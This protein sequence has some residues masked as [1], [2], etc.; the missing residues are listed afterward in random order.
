MATQKI[1]LVRHGQTDYNLQG[2]VQG[3]GIDASLNAT[4]NAQAEAFFRAYGD[5]DFSVVH[6]SQLNR[7]KESVAGFIKKGIPH[8][9]HAA[10]NE[11]SW[12]NREG[13]RI[14]PEEDEYYHW[15]LNQWQIGK[16]S[17]AIEGGESPDDVAARQKPFVDMLRSMP[18][19]RPVLICM[20]G[21]AMR[22]LLCQILNYPLRCM[23]MFQHRNLCLYLLH[24]TQAQFVVEAYDN[25]EHLSLMNISSKGPAV[26]IGK[27]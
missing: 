8:E 4:G 7:S 19:G 11:I 9:V 23:D 6:T 3:S 25:T 14:T 15:L 10:L 12:G 22:I 13:Q 16:T 26:N 27:K 17:I 24:R 21:R 5:I 1:Y 20:H 18:S 2:I